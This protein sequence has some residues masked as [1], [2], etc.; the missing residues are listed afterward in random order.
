MQAIDKTQRESVVGQSLFKLIFG[1]MVLP[2][3]IDRKLGWEGREMQKS[4]QAEPENRPDNVESPSTFPRA[5]KAPSAM[6]PP[7]RS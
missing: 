2:A 1:D 4:E 3:F 6:M 7:T 5:R